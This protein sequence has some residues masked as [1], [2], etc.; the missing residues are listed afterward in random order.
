MHGNVCSTWMMLL[1]LDGIFVCLVA[2]S[3]VSVLDG[4]LLSCLMRACGFN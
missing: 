2:T 4:L 3:L 1:V